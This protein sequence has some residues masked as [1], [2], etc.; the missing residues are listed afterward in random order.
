[1]TNFAFILTKKS[2][3]DKYSTANS[4]RVTMMKNNKFIKMLSFIALCAFLP[5]LL[6]I[7]SGASAFDY[8][9]LTAAKYVKTESRRTYIDA[10]MRQYIEDQ[11]K[12]QTLL[13]N[14][15]AVV[16]LFE[17]GSDNTVAEPDYAKTR[18]DHAV[19]LTVKNVD[20]APQVVYGYGSCSTLPD[21][22]LR[23]SYRTSTSVEDGKQYTTGPA[24]LL[25]GIYGLKTVNH[26]SL[27]CSFDTMGGSGYDPVRSVYL[28][29]GGK[30]IIGASSSIFI[31]I[32]TSNHTTT[33]GSPWSTGCLTVFTTD[34]NVYNNFAKSVTDIQI[35][36][37]KF[38]S[39]GVQVGCVVVNR[40]LYREQLYQLYKCDEAV[41][42]LLAGSDAYPVCEHDEK[43]ETEGRC[44]KC[45]SYL[46]NKDN[47]ADCKI[48]TY[49]LSSGTVRSNPYDIAD[50]VSKASG[51]VEVT[52][53]V[54]NGLGQIWYVTENGYIRADGLKFEKAAGSALQIKPKNT[55]YTVSL[56]KSCDIGGT[57]SS[58]YKLT[59]VTASLDGELYAD[60]KPN[61]KTLDMGDASKGQIN[62][63]DAAKLSL[64]AHKITVTAEDGSGNTVQCEITLN[65]TTTYDIEYDANGGSGAPWS[66]KKK[67]GT[68]YVI[69]QTKPKRQ[70]YI[71][72]GWSEDKNASEPTYL[73]GDRFTLD[74]NA[75]LY[76][77]WE[78]G[79]QT[80]PVTTEARTE[81]QTEPETV[82]ET[83]PL[84]E[85]QTGPQTEP[86]VTGTDTEPVSEE[87]GL[88]VVLIIAIIA[89]SAAVSA[90]AVFVI[91]AGKRTR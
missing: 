45:G 64:G 62:S 29:S 32:K 71:F 55:A 74:K 73:P 59:H 41:N 13:K 66:A 19:I 70:G 26:S 44:G 30:Y 12:L 67:Y 14:G 49:S 75:K 34:R 81:K 84:T 35:S 40:Q 77:V 51:T 28:R 42:A 3:C 16:F 47:E 22:F 83:E 88:N 24:T 1:M 79:E 38:V 48:G 4:F 61:S 86:A 36:D 68:D 69:S 65:V 23:Y 78:E 56:G 7:P 63:F 53:A 6:C 43:Y 8:G 20:G 58:N 54:I 33:G 25:D 52:G 39:T 57:V 31:H 60:I 72:K 11:P 5:P 90:G 10:A 27:G 50:E 18:R 9:G 2:F 80:E 76:A 82:T 91:R 21:D 37:N 46:R 85:K 17:G 89:V 87:K 15:K